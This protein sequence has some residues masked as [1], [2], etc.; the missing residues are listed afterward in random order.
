MYKSHLVL[1][2]SHLGQEAQENPLTLMGDFCSRE[3][4]CR[5]E[6]PSPQIGQQLQEGKPG[7][8]SG[9][10]RGDFCTVN[11]PKLLIANVRT[12]SQTKRNHPQL[13]RP[14]SCTAGKGHPPAQSQPEP[15][16]PYLKEQQPS[17]ADWS[18]LFQWPPC[19]AN[20][21]VLSAP[22]LKVLA[23]PRHASV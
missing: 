2:R 12:I 5:K 14:P 15:G 17:S 16:L 4:R 8:G 18:R 10:H 9:T 19:Y 22:L 23:M 7:P 3:R 13:H 6:P 11:G 21:R 1:P 20:E